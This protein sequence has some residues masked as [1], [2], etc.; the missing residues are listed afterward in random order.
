MLPIEE[1]ELLGRLE[2]ISRLKRSP[3]AI[4]RTNDRVRAILEKQIQTR[5]NFWI[6]N[7][8]LLSG[9]AAGILLVM[10]ITIHVFQSRH[11]LPK[12]AVN[13]PTA[14]ASVP[15]AAASEQGPA[16]ALKLE[17]E[18]A[19]RMLAVQYPTGQANVRFFRLYPVVQSA[20]GRSD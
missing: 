7:R 19:K 6:R 18:T 14:M 12:A 9:L 15:L 11:L 3:E 1:S 17:G 20:S 13:L 10:G 4:R 16:D 5:R 8:F 2:R